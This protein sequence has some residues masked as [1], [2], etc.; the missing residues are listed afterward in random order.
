VLAHRAFS[1]IELTVVREGDMD[2][3]TYYAHS[4]NAT[5][6]WHL[7]ADHLR[8]VGATAERLAGAAAWAK[9]A[10]LAGRLH[11]IGKY[12]DLFQCRLRGEA[13]GIDH[14]SLGA[15]LALWDHKAI[16]AALACEGHHI[17]LQPGGLQS[18]RRL[19]P[20]NLANNHALRLKLS[21]P[22]PGRLVAC[23]LADGLSFATPSVRAVPAWSAAVADMLEV[24]MLFSCLVDA[25]FLDTEAHFNGDA[26]GKR[27]RQPGP[28]LHPETALAALNRFMESSVRGAVRA[29]PR[30]LAARESLW[31][32][33]GHAAQT[34]TAL[35]TLTAPTGSGKTLA[36]LRFA[37]EHAAHNKLRRVVLAVPFL[38]IIEQTARTYRQVFAGFPAHFILEHHS[39]AGLGEKSE[40]RDA[41]GA[42][43]RQRRLLVARAG[44]RPAN[45]PGVD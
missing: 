22:D 1:E 3:P 6:D 38:T 19:L 27:Y 44:H 45:W 40:R 5:G 34:T 12:G 41:E 13:S 36:M 2:K 18:L 7:L 8:S 32:A 9:E 31:Q 4:A 28:E 14:W 17:G 10:G 20:D 25:D 35:F 11:D 21:E 37:L 42:Q 16:A 30:V 26:Q 43:E 15:W 23:A 29:D 39:L 24:R 33:T